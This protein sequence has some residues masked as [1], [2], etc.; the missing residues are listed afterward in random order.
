M[1]FDALGRHA[2]Q[3]REGVPA[4]V[5]ARPR[6]SAN[7]CGRACGAGWNPARSPAGEASARAGGSWVTVGQASVCRFSRRR[8]IRWPVGKVTGFKEYTREMPARRAIEERV[9]D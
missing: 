5:Q 1:D 9:Y 4:R 6:R 7:S 2:A 3:V 8:K